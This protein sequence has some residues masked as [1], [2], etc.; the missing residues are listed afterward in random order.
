MSPSNFFLM[1]KH[2]LSKKKKKTPER[3]TQIAI[4]DYLRFQKECVVMEIETSGIFDHRTRTHRAKRPNQ[5]SLF[6]RGVSDLL[7][8][9][10]RFGFI[11]IEVKSEV[12]RLSDVQ[13]DFRDAVLACG[14]KHL[15]ARS[16]EDVAEFFRLLDTLSKPLIPRKSGMNPE[17]Q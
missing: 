10:K 12:G 6:F 5:G 8:L 9:H 2:S 11:A 7:V 17:G 13:K 4:L 15:M 1:L 3:F 14:G 16:V